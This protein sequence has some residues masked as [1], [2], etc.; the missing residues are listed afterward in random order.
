MILILL[1]A[2]T[3][4]TVIQVARMD[5]LDLVVLKQRLFLFVPFLLLV[6]AKLGLAIGGRS[7]RLK[8]DE[9]TKRQT[10]EGPG[11]ETSSS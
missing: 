3:M 4:A 5:P 2:L 7:R 9:P 8:A 10:D 1:S 11:R 6:V